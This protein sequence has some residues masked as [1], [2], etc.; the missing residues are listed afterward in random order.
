MPS[1]LENWEGATITSNHP[2]TYLTPYGG[3][4][5]GASPDATVYSFGNEQVAKLEVEASTANSLC[6]ADPG[7]I[8]RVL[9]ETPLN[10][11]NCS[12]FECK[13]YLAE[14]TPQTFTQAGCFADCVPGW[15]IRVHVGIDFDWR[16]VGSLED[17][18]DWGEYGFEMNQWCYAQAE[19]GGG[20]TCKYISYGE[21]ETFDTFLNRIDKWSTLPKFDSSSEVPWLNGNYELT[22]I[23]LNCSMVLYHPDALMP[24]GNINM[25][26]YF[27]DIIIS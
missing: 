9:P 7:V 21:A 22:A 23:Y 6:R 11:K 20:Y 17:Y 8:L 26:V 13:A 1:W 27:S 19:E 24:H 15:D 5:S 2:W 10:L 18:T 3:G 14:F 12:G 4:C 25:K 16:P